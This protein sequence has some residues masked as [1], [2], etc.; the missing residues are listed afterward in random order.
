MLKKLRSLKKYLKVYENCN[1]IVKMYTITYCIDKYST[2]VPKS[3][4]RKIKY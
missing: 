3:I 4:N 1:N 2:L